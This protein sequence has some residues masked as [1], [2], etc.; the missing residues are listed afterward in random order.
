MAPLLPGLRLTEP[1]GEKIHL[2]ALWWG[3]GFGGN[4]WQTMRRPENWI[5]RTFTWHASWLL[6]WGVWRKM[7]DA[8][9]SIYI[10]FIV[11]VKLKVYECTL[12]L[13]LVT[14]Q[15]LF[16]SC[17]YS[18]NSNMWRCRFTIAHKFL[19]SELPRE[20]RQQ[21]YV[22]VGAICFTSGGG[23]ICL[24]ITCWYATPGGRCVTV[25][26]VGEDFIDSSVDASKC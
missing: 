26:E 18:K 9:A 8:A 4:N 14:H 24:G 12:L 16:W 11:I 10:F 3:T 19:I 5:M 2:R 13:F 1:G 17:F 23:S 22:L 7:S 20:G 6:S 15:N 21:Q 25:W